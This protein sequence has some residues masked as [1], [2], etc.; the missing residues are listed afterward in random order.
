MF[1]SSSMVTSLLN[2]EKNQFLK[3]VRPEESKSM[4]Q[5]GSRVLKYAFLW[6]LVS[7]LVVIKI[8]IN[9]NN[10][11]NNRIFSTGPQWSFGACAFC[12]ARCQK[13]G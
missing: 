11:N 8:K 5:H 7:L 3:T 6:G 10:N 12:S 2:Q 4:T 1:L 9:N 13:W